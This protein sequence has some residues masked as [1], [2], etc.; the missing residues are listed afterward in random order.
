MPYADLRKGE[1]RPGQVDP[2]DAAAGI[3]QPPHPRGVTRAQDLDEPDAEV[4]SPTPIRQRVSSTPA[5]PTRSPTRSVSILRR[6]LEPEAPV[7][8]LADEQD[9]SAEEPAPQDTDEE[10]IE[11]IP[12]DPVPGAEPSE[13]SVQD[14]LAVI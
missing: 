1:S 12:C 9:E 2:F 11:N 4:G 7:I 8:M 6:E 13:A 3:A 10:D 14:V 5:C